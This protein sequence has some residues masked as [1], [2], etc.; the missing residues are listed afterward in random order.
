MIALPRSHF[1]ELDCHLA[2]VLVNH[3]PATG[4]TESHLAA[5]IASA[6]ARPGRLFRATLV[7]RTLTVLGRE[8]ALADA[9][10]CG[11]EYYHIASLLLDDLP[12]M[13]DAMIRRGYACPHLEHGDATVILSALAFVNRAYALIW[14]ELAPLPL[15]LRLA[16]N[17]LLDRELGLAGILN[18]QAR[19]LRFSEHPQPGREAAQ[20]AIGKTVALFRLALGFPALIGGASAE[21]LRQLNQLCVRWGLWY[22]ACN[23]LADVHARPLP[24]ASASRDAA[25]TR[26]NLR[27]ALGPQAFNRRRD[28]LVR[29]AALTI[30]QLVRIN[31]VWGFLWETQETLVLAGDEPMRPAFYSQAS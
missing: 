24:G 21:E 13:D 31:P 11:I 6:L 29:Q 23:D 26:P 27:L 30:D 18:G 19:D 22:Q 4:T 17:Q 10:A 3:F 28:R 7:W 15:A 14:R 8:P 1:A 25:L 12:C 20:I 5:V 16:A 2:R 9:L